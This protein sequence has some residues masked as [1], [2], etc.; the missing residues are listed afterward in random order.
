M[1]PALLPIREIAAKLNIADPFIEPWGT[2]IAKLRLELLSAPRPP[3][4]RRLILVTAM[5]S[6]SSGEGKTVT[7]IGLAQALERIGKTAI[8]TLRE[9]SLGPVFGLKGGATGGGQSEVL[10]S[11]R[12]NLHFSGD[13]HAVTSAHNLLAAMLDA[14]VHHGNP[15]RIDLNNVLWTRTMDMND[16]SLRTVVSGLG[17]LTN[18]PARE[19]GF[20]I[21]AASEI[22]AIL[23]LTCSRQD[24]R[25][26]LDQVVVALDYDRKAIR[27]QD[28]HATGAMMV[29]LNDA[30]M[31][32]LVQTT[33]HTP[34]IIHTGPF[35]NIAHGTSS[36]LS[37]RMALHLADYVVN[38]T[39][40]AAD[41]GAE[42]YCDIVM[43]ASGLQPSAA[44]L[45]VSVR[46]IQRQ[47]GKNAST[48]PISASFQAGFANIAKHLDTL[49]KFGVPVVVA[50]NKFPD[51]KV[52]QLGAIERFCCDLNVELAV[53]DV[54]ERGGAGGVDLAE[55][56]V[57]AADCCSIGSVRTLYSPDLP[58]REKIET[59]AREVYG[60][61]E[62]V[63][64]PAARK[65]LEV[66]TQRGYG[67]LPVCMAKTQASL[68][69]DPDVLGAPVGWTLTVRDAELFAGA[70]FVVAVTGEMM[71]MPGLGKSPQAFR[72][73]VDDKTGKI[74][75]L[76]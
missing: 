35:A 73:D 72:V 47:G 31:P 48:L 60:A 11:E 5:T 39:G 55:K 32:N 59:I 7:S 16:R 30:L 58:L 71:L 61:G 20:V 15:L 6:T 18:G 34:A 37:L 57:D 25:R 52:E 45:I 12:I 2:H 17:G 44:V 51:D 68:T 26:R 10:P 64:E 65:K 40:F 42:K 22:M 14:H 43:P 33:E 3:S 69:D 54:Y 23:G 27:A 24:L 21:T 75:G 67:Q 63:F 74:Q 38:E 29:L 1:P 4:K 36:V 46:S 50:I 70:G 62:V 8:V 76:I 19:T 13:F 28:L 53:S 66:F 9:P 41:L 49:R 56:V